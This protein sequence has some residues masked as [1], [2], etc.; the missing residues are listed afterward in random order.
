LVFYVGFLPK[1]ILTFKLRIVNV[2]FG[3]SITL[4]MPG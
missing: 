1:Q 4:H 2:K 3:I